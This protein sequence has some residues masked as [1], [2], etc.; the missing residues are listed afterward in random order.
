MR[1]DLV[2]RKRRVR[3][4]PGHTVR[5][6]GCTQKAEGTPG[7]LSMIGQ[8]LKG[9]QKCLRAGGRARERELQLHEVWIEHSREYLQ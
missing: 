2:E 7:V 4:D 3:L 6:P 1:V 8:G 5:P 9:P